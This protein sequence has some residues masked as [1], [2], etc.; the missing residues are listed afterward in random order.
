MKTLTQCPLC[1]SEAL[2][3]LPFE[4]WYQF[5]RYPGSKCR[6]CGLAFLSVQPDRD[7]LTEMYDAD[8]FESDFRC[9][10]EPAA[11]LGGEQS[12]KVFAE[13][14]KS[15]LELIRGLTGRKGGRLLEIGS[16]GGWF[17]KAA[18]EQG[19][20][21]KGVE[22]SREAA[23]FARQKLGLDVF[24]GELAEAK[25]PSG[26]FD[27]V[28][29]ADVLE[30]V[31][32]PVAFVREVRRILADGGHAVV[33]GPTA[34]NALSRRLGLAAYSLAKKTRSIAL[35]PYHLFEYTPRTIRLLFEDSGFKVVTLDS[36]KIRPSLRAF[37]LEDIVM[38]GLDLVNWPATTL[39]CVWG[40]RVIL[41][42][43][44][45]QP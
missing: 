45:G 30:H 36:K 23:D 9:G 39:F 29:M 43:R 21:A 26:S 22:L 25:F 10:S 12:E 18:R 33:C 17:L 15:A 11:G 20:E 44:A 19:W 14:A 24:C 16:A 41:C 38:F 6:A 32:E 1:G 3:R 13:E 40:D 2:S 35:A 8:Y 34:L 37:N 31:A 7:T 5:E 28:Y 42:A 4:Y 27:V